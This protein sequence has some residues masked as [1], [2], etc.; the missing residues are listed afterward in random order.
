LSAVDGS[1]APDGQDVVQ[2]YSPAPVEPAG[3]WD[4]WRGEAERRLEDKAEE[5][6]P[7]FRRLQIGTFVETAQDLAV[8]TGAE[9]GC[10]YH[11]DN[12]PTRIGPI[13]PA[14]GA[15]G[16]RTAVQ[17]LYIGSA[18]CHPGGGVSGLPGKH[19]AAVVLADL[20]GDRPGRLARAR[21]ALRAR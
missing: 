2:L 11:I 9:N 18:S 13:R 19:C 14:A 7:D 12:L 1:Q 15:G 20:N 6:A 5:V 8:R 10:I 4:K 16:Y 3:G 17:G 21:K